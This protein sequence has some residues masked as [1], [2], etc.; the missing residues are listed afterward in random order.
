[1]VISRQDVT[2]S[3]LC[4]GFKKCGTK[5]VHTFLFPKSSSEIRK[6]TVLG[7]FRDSAIIIDAIRQTFLT[8]SAKAEMFTSVQVDSGRSLL[9]SS[10]T[11][12]LP[13]RNREYYLK[14]FWLVQ[15]PIPVSFF[16]NTSVS[17]ADRLALKQNF[18]AS[19]KLSTCKV[20]CIDYAKMLCIYEHVKSCASRK[21]YVMGHLYLQILIQL[22]RTKITLFYAKG[23]K[24]V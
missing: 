20:I 12:S 6:T 18:M 9:S 13:S 4:W 23:W 14:T 10:S 8:K 1:V 17:V 7:M 11:R 24:I 22:L 16:T 21:R 15:S 3:L 19:L 2:R 5:R